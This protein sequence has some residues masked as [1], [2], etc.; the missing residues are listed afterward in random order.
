[1]KTRT[2]FLVLALMLPAAGNVSASMDCN[3]NMLTLTTEQY[4]CL[5]PA[6]KKLNN[7]VRRAEDMLSERAAQARK[8]CLN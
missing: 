5:S 6:L 8:N 7:E 3:K 2:V 1:M 4:V